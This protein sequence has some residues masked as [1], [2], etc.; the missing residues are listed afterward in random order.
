MDDRPQCAAASFRN[1]FCL[2][3]GRG[4][5]ILKR[6]LV[7]L[8]ILAGKVG[9]LADAVNSGF[10]AGRYQGSCLIDRNIGHGNGGIHLVA[11]DR[12]SRIPVVNRIK[13]IVGGLN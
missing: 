10:N 9:D 3:F 8:V 1:G 13:P 7:R 12:S 6:L 4:D 5:G 2:D 11:C